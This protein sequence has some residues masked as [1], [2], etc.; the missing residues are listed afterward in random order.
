M[1]L[2][3]DLQQLAVGGH[4]FG[5]SK[6]ASGGAVL[7]RQPSDAAAEHVASDPTVPEK[8]LSGASPCGCAAVMTSRHFAPASV[9]AM[10]A[11][12]DPRD[13]SDGA[14][15]GMTCTLV[16]LATFTSSASFAGRGCPCPPPCAAIDNCA[17]ERS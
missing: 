5:R 17:R 14:E 7:A 15:T 2:A 11:A 16:I 10:P 12:P 4:Q 3:V 13:E 9:R 6:A 8:P 1:V